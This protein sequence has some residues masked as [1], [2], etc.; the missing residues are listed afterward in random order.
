[1]KS[2]RHADMKVRPM[3]QAQYGSVRS[4][5]RVVKCLVAVA[6][7]HDALAAAYLKYGWDLSA[8]KSASFS[9]R[10]RECA[11]SMTPNKEVNIER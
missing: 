6:D 8:E 2:I 9:R 4:L 11:K 10:L 5:K 1:M 3:K 7:A